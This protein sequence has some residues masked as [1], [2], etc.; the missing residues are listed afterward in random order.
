M[1]RRIVSGFILV[2]S[3]A[4]LAACGSGAGTTDLLMGTGSQ[5]GT[6][7]PLGAEMANVWNNQIEHI[8]VTST[9]S[10]ASVENLAKISRGE[11]DL[12]MSVNLPAIDAYEGKGEFEGNPVENFAFIGHIYPEVMQIVSRESTGVETIADLAGK[13][14]AIGPP[15]SGTQAAAKLILEAYG[16]QDGD[17]VAYQEGFGDA[18]AKLQDGTIDA[19]FGLLGLPDAGIDELQA[20]TRDVKFLEVT[21]DALAHIEANSGYS[22]FAISAGSYEWLEADAH[23]ISA[24]AILVANT[25]TVDE[26]L[27]YELARVMIEHNGDNTHPQSSHTTQE[28]AL[29]GSNGLPIHPGAQ[30][31]Y[32]EIGLMD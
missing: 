30:K 29:N 2:L 11:F 8:N 16:L 5:G 23:T 13:R 19:S 12:G 24:F 14:V 17:Y 21:G 20:A 4:V 31:Y 9:E 7:F 10:G 28:N 32:Q 6:Y 26:D 22:G 3:V 25:D 1:K 27:A 15:G 18:K